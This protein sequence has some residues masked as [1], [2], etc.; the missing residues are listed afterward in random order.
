MELIKNDKIRNVAII[1]HVDHGK[2][3]LVDAFIK[4]SHLFRDNQEEMEQDRILDSNDLE[5]EKGI[6]ITAKNISIAYNGYKINIIDTPGH[7]DFGGEVERTLNMAE[8]CVLV[9]DA[10]EEVMPQTRFVLRKAFEANLKP[11]VVIN[12]IDKKLANPQKTL[13]SIQDLF[14]DLATDESQLDFKTFYAV[15]R[16]GKVFAELPDAKDNDYSSFEG[17]VEPLL[18]AMVSEIPAPQGDYDQPFLMQSSSLDFNAHRGLYVIGKVLRGILKVNDSI[19]VVNASKEDYK[20]TGKVKSLFVKEGLEYKEV[21]EVGVGEVVAIA[22]LDNVGIGDTVCSKDKVEALPVIDISPPSLKMRFEAN[23]SPF[24]G[25]EGK[26]P[27]WTQIQARLDQE[28]QTNVGLTIENNHDGSYSVSGR[29]ELHLAILIES[30]RREGYEFQIRKP[31]VISKVIDGVELDPLEEVYIEAPEQYYSSVSQ[32]VNK[33]KGELISIKNEGTLS[34]LVYHIFARNLIGMR[35]EL[36]NLT[37]GEVVISNNFHSYAKLIKAE[38]DTVSGRMVSQATGK[39]LA[40]SLNSLQ[41]RGILLIEPNVDIYEGM[42]IGI[43]KYD[44]DMIVNP[45][46]AREKS[47]VRMSRAEITLVNLKAPMEMTLEVAIPMIRDDEIL[48][49]TPENIRLRKKYLNK[50]AEYDANKR[51]TKA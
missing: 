51:K 47:N 48:E 14:L 29:G 12:K 42:I 7:A 26:F 8:G 44:T 36:L 6:T 39:A 25:K 18:K 19:V 1:A 37:K 46:K 45:T 11:I 35:R 28:A 27:N 3:T 34:K 23:T 43:S 13:G 2:T 33:R 41:E 40:Y 20:I 24:L 38:M 32:E 17:T 31:E 16:D 10:Q 4:Q 49:I 50:Q 21:T 9:V 5:R 30:M 22:G 15:A